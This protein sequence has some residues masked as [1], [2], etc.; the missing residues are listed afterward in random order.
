LGFRGDTATPLLALDAVAMQK[1]GWKWFPTRMSGAGGRYFKKSVHHV[2]EH[3][4]DGHR[5]TGNGAQH[6]VNEHFV[7]GHRHHH[8]NEHFVDGHRHTGNG[9]GN[10]H[11]VDEMVDDNRGLVFA[12][13]YYSNS[14]S[15]TGA[16]RLHPEPSSSTSRTC[17]VASDG[18][19]QAAQE[20]S[21]STSQDS[22]TIKSETNLNPM[23]DFVSP[24]SEESDSEITHRKYSRA[25]CCDTDTWGIQGHPGC[26]RFQTLLSFSN[27]CQDPLQL[28]LQPP[29]NYDFSKEQ[30]VDHKVRGTSL[31]RTCVRVSAIL[32]ATSSGKTASATDGGERKNGGYER[33]QAHGRYMICTRIAPKEMRVF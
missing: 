7:D 24:A 30:C 16:A 1:L 15:N 5:H 32:S 10:Q 23:F 8:V 29:V 21:Q 28:T 9:D 14:G 19:V 20:S 2:N 4:V 31:V 17:S 33:C 25:E 26:Q 11:M 3:F 12:G 22:S 18:S 6:H 13:S 27:Y